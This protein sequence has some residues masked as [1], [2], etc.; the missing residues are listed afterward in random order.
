MDPKV[1]LGV[2]YSSKSVSELS[3][4]SLDELDDLDAFSPDE[5][6]GVG[7]RR[8]LLSGFL[9]PCRSFE[10]LCR[11]RVFFFRL[12]VSVSMRECRVLYVSV[13]SSGGVIF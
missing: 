13:E 2:S 5:V 6:S 4:L 8:R 3:E 11:D 1:V 9:F 10:E 7:D 12:P